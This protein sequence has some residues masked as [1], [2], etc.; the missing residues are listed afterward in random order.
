MCVEIGYKQG[1]TALFYLLFIYSFLYYICVEIG[2]KIVFT[3][4]FFMY[5]ITFF[6]I[7]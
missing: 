1:G 7:D 3:T 5:Y 2:Y 4:D 6:K